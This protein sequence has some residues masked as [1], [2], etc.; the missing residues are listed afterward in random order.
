MALFTKRKKDDYYSFEN[1][2]K[3]FN[4]KTD[5]DMTPKPFHILV[6]RLLSEELA[7]EGEIENENS[8]NQMQGPKIK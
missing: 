2:V 4:E 8:A 3:R 1:M 6:G 5:I 7:D